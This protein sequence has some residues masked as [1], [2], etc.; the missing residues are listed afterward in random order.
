MLDKNAGLQT[1][2]PPDTQP[3]NSI[4]KQGK[5]VDYEADSHTR[6]QAAR[7]VRDMVS[8][9]K[10]YKLQHGRELFV[11]GALG[12]LFAVAK[13]G[14]VLHN[15]PCTEG[16]DGRLGKDFVEVKTISPFKNEPF[17]QVKRSGNWG[18]LVVV[19][20][21]EDFAV[22]CRVHARKKLP[23]G[24]GEFITVPWSD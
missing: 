17:V 15:D 9:A 20:V 5:P 24:K 7:I 4:G 10:A 3:Q 23:K 16:S 12:E 19:R 8:A 22:D 11:Y 13:L 1:P 18:K 14:V 2:P 21:Y 6:L